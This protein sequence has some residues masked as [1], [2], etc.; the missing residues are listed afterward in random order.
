MAAA[1]SRFA[2]LL[3]GLRFEWLADEAFAA[4]VAQ[5][6]ATGQHRNPDPVGRPEWFTT[7]WFHRPDE[8]QSE[9]TGAGLQVEAVLAVEGP[10]WLLGDLDRRW[11]DDDRR[12]RLLQAGGPSKMRPAC[13]GSALTCWPSPADIDPD[14]L[15]RG[16]SAGIVA[17]FHV[18]CTGLTDGCAWGI[19]DPQ[20]R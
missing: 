14:R 12:D 3:D 11:E 8:L 6:L 5:D 19:F 20:K 4:I 17:A 15:T 7:A 18:P 2:S 16:G 1:I 9:L 10:L 13:S